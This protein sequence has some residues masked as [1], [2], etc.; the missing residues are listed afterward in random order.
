MATSDTNLLTKHI[1]PINLCILSFYVGGR[2]LTTDSITL[3]AISTLFSWTCLSGLFLYFSFY[4][5]LREPWDL[6]RAFWCFWF[7][8]SFPHENTI[9][10]NQYY[11]IHFL[12]HCGI[13][14]VYSIIG[15][16]FMVKAIIDSKWCVK[17]CRCKLF[18]FFGAEKK[19]LM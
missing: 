7:F 10:I 8:P 16:A 18:F 3:E 12:P 9:Y 15:K 2:I 5:L 14:Q 17:M 13:Q 11:K 19:H 1:I 4:Y 6:F